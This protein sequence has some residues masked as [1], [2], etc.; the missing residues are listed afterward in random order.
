MKKNSRILLAA[1]V[2]FWFAQY[3]YIPFQT[4]YLTGT[5]ISSQMIGV[6]VG[7]YG[8]SQMLLRLPVG[9]LA[10]CRDHHK[11][12]IVSGGIFAG[13]A[14]I[15]R[16]VSGSG[17]GY[18]VANLFSGLASAM[19]IS[20]MVLYMS[21]YPAQQ[22]KAT[23]QLIFANNLGMLAGF[24]TSTVLY[25]R[26]GMGMI[27]LFSVCAGFGCALTA[28][29]LET[30]KE[31]K[32]VPEVTVRSLLSVCKN[33]RLWLFSLLAL[34]QQGVQMSTTMSFTTQII[35]ELGAD[36]FLTGC[37]SVIYMLSA[38]LWAKFATTECCN[39]IS[40][41]KWII[42]VFCTTAVYCFFVP[43]STSTGMVCVLQI[44]PGMATG[45]LLS[46]LTSEAM[47]EI[48]AEKRSTAMG[49]FQAVYA[50]GMTGFPVICG[51]IADGISMNAAYTVLAVLC[52]LAAAGYGLVQVC[53]LGDG[54]EKRG[55]KRG[56]KIGVVQ[57][58]EQE[59]Q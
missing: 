52:I 50:L 1:V 16:V 56:M 31:S 45:I 40:P 13:T 18:L 5:G 36:T 25:E 41:K 11:L 59:N 3:V 35:R 44:L 33:R 9:V 34:V 27:C 20:F 30:T 8:I 10:D 42:L 47:K 21:Y 17:T 4:P 38:V 14:S 54:I 37:A 32:A 6:I 55:I 53:S 43:K 15:F 57:G 28:M 49:F 23:G 7:A 58:T 39:R 19:W 51:K 46:F 12:F 2:F 26:L 22:Q 48:P 24:M 29:F